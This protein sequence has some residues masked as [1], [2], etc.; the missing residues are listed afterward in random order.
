M[1]NTLFGILFVTAF[2]I[3][4]QTD[5]L[6]CGC[7]SMGLT[8]EQEING[9][10]ENNKAVF[11]GEV[12][13]IVDRAKDRDVTFRVGEY[14]KGDVLE[15]ITVSTDS[16]NSSCAFHFEVGKSYLVF[17]NLWEG[18]LYTAACSRNRDL[19]KADEVL[20]VLGKGETPVKKKP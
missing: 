5:A 10:L 7:P 20:K 18:S 6:A 19:K 1:A 8:L 9:R 17:A 16:L 12:L 14:W 11:S 4:G 3:F 13:E 2:F 15:Q